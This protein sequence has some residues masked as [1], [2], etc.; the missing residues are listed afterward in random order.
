MQS[1]TRYG[2]EISVFTAMALQAYE[3]NVK[4]HRVLTKVIHTDPIFLRPPSSC[5]RS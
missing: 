1:V 5:S 3:R 2:T 4:Q